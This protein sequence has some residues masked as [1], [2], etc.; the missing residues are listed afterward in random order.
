[1]AFQKFPKNYL[2]ISMGLL[3][4]HPLYHQQQKFFMLFW[5]VFKWFRLCYIIIWIVS[6]ILSQTSWCLESLL[7]YSI[8]L[9]IGITTSMYFALSIWV[10]FIS[11]MQSL[12]LLVF[13]IPRQSSFISTQVFFRKWVGWFRVLSKKF[14]IFWYSIIILLY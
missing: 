4:Q 7:R 6:V 13:Y 12:W 3:F 8:K 2:R 10:L 5:L 9:Y 11:P 14:I 1:M